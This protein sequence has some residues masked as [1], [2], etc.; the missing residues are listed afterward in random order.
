MSEEDRPGESALPRIRSPGDASSPSAAR[1]YRG[2][3]LQ[4]DVAQLLVWG[5]CS[6]QRLRHNNRP[7]EKLGTFHRQPAINSCHGS[8]RRGHGWSLSLDVISLSTIFAATGTGMVS[9]RK[10][11]SS[12]LT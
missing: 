12:Y 2:D 9:I 4:P 8:M 6:L 11:F 1:Y 5:A 7:S 3:Q 10:S